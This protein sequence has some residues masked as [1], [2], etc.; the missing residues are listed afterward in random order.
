MLAYA[1]CVLARTEHNYS[2][3]ACPL[4]EDLPFSGQGHLQG[5]VVW[6]AWLQASL[7]TVRL[8]CGQ[9]R[10][11]RTFAGIASLILQ[12]LA[13]RSIQIRCKRSAYGVW[14]LLAC[15]GPRVTQ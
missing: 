14:S 11:V 10:S 15:L 1:C 7:M 8:P 13:F 12:A 9:V 6:V 4:S 5:H 3:L 2:V